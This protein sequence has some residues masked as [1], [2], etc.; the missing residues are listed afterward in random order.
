[1]NQEASLDIISEDKQHVILG[2]AAINLIFKQEEVTVMTLIRELNAMA[3][4][5]PEDDR[6]ITIHA[7][8]G[9]LRD[10]RRPGSLSE[11]GATSFTPSAFS[12]N[13][14]RNESIILDATPEQP[15]S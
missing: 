12:D 15:E 6:L 9:W 2:E 1:M 11:H 5:E 7:A 8:R 10:F 4:N 14:A 3:E 13:A